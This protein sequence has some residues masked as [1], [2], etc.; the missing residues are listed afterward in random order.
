MRILAY[1]H[2]HDGAAVLVEDGR[3]VY[4]LESEKDDGKRHD[5]LTP[6]LFLRS[7]QCSAAPD[8]V[9]VSGWSSQRAWTGEIYDEVA[10]H[11]KRF[12][13][14]VEGGYMDEGPRGKVASRTV[15]AG[16][17]IERFSS[18]H[19]R[20]HILCSYGLS[21]F[22]QGEPCYALVWEG[23]IGAMYY[24][25]EQVRISKLGDV[26]LAPGCRYQLLYVLADPTFPVADRDWVRME[27]AGKLM[28]LA[29]YGR[30]APRTTEQQAVIERIMSM[31]IL[32]TLSSGPTPKQQLS[33]S[34]FCN[35][36]FESQEFR[37]LAYHLTAALFDKFHAFAKKHVQRGLP[38]IIAGG[39]GLNCDW[40]SQWRDCGLFRDVFVPPCPND[41]GVAIGA[42]IDALHHYTGR[43]KLEW[44]VYAGEHFVED[45][46]GA[47]G[48]GSKPVDLSEVCHCLTNGEVIGWAQGRYEIGPRALGNR[49]LLAAPFTEEM[50]DRLNRIKQREPF[51][52][53]AP[54]CLEED[55]ALHFDDPRP[56]PHMLYFQRVKSQNLRAVTHAD[57]SARAQSVNDADNPAMCALLREFKRVTGVGVLCNTSLNFKGRGF[58]N[59]LSQL[60]ALAAERQIDGIVA[61]SKFWRRTGTDR[62]R[63]AG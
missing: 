56:S 4:S 48:F 62:G 33:G 45:S 2:A 5:R 25:D 16:R 3:L 49:S 50:R 61:G 13:D 6:S 32:G 1:N 54:I 36:G 63:R 23:V 59:H 58:V 31:D 20:S 42:A 41:S 46:S 18:S 52:P 57:G 43:A 29:A 55:F 9:A 34:G 22:P 12:L 27:D 7:L 11:H 44:N 10:T 39:C 28:A 47:W 51:R 53:I 38:L 14:Q 24:V 40:N 21:S 37:D 8:V 60:F 15:F 26:L 19:V 17:E 35:I 30:R